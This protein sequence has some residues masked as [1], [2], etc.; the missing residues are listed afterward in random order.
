[1]FEAL[2]DLVATK[3]GEFRAARDV[4]YSAARQPGAQFH[5]PEGQGYWHDWEGGRFNLAQACA[6]VGIT[7][8]LYTDLLAGLSRTGACEILKR[9]DRSGSLEVGLR[10]T[11]NIGIWGS[12]K[13][14]EYRQAVPSPIV[15]STKP[16]N[17]QPDGSARYVPLDRD[18][19]YI[20][21]KW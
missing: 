2:R 10:M 18:G 21:R 14:I 20:V 7:E 6:A 5:K 4:L 17:P 11:D 3:K 8:A 16:P 15:E 13:W 1:V 9:T 12:E 19:W